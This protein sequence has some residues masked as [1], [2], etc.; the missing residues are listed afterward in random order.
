M[1]KFLEF[2]K[3]SLIIIFLTACGG[4]GGDSSSSTTPPPPSKNISGT[5]V[6]GYIKDAKICLDIN[7]NSQCDDNEP[8]T[9]SDEN[10]N[11]TLSVTANNGEYKIISVGGVDM[12]TR[13]V[14][15]G[16]MEERVTLSDDNTYYKH[17]NYTINNSSFKNL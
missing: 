6:D 7:N 5:I 16:V 17:N 2:I 13:E 1:K 3:I 9:I 4:G 11:Y 10:G 12:A 14:F 8:Y 15:D